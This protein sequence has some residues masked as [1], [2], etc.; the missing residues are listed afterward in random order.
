MKYLNRHIV[1]NIAACW[2][3][4]GYELLETEREDE[5]QLNTIKSEPSLGNKER[6]RKMLTLWLD[7]K[8][9]ASW[10]DLIR[11]LRVPSIGLYTIALDI[12]ARLLPEGKHRAS[13]PI[14]MLL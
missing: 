7:K 13:I 10:N 14:C 5:I 2:Q 11:A 1:A 3:D 4:V 6:A 9:D 12:K 8:P